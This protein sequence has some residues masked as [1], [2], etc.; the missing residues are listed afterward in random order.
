MKK[1]L[2]II[3][4]VCVIST[5]LAMPVAVS[6]A[7]AASYQQ[8]VKLDAGTPCADYPV[9][10]FFDNDES[11]IGFLAAFNDNKN[12]VV[13]TLAIDLGA[14]YKLSGF[15][16]TIPTTKERKELLSEIGIT[17][18]DSTG[19]KNYGEIN[20][21]D[22]GAIRVSNTA[23]SIKADG[24]FD[25]GS[26]A[27]ALNGNQW[28]N[29]VGTNLN[30][31]TAYRY[32]YITQSANFGLML[33]DLK[34]LDE[35]GNDLMQ[36]NKEFIRFYVSP[37]IE[38]GYEDISEFGMYIV[39]FDLFNDDAR[40]NGVM[41]KME[42][43]LA[44]GQNYAADLTNIPAGAVNVPVIAVPFLKIGGSYAFGDAS[45]QYTLNGLK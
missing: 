25:Y 8:L 20:Q 10:N 44:E 34:I 22:Y 3:L 40:L 6:A 19:A 17:D 29:A 5:L 21:S 33:K 14:A 26:D 45:A 35:N 38:S 24:S 18:L 23:I 27:V 39:P 4:A 42:G 12:A 2:S 15:E 7:P 28:D 16:Y 11:T 41:A 32:V 31:N 9:S 36:S 1:F 37:T 43:S 13:G 30:T